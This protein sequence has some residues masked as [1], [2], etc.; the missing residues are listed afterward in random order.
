MPPAS[1][2]SSLPADGMTSSPA[3]PANGALLPGAV[4]RHATTDVPIC[5]PEATAAEVR[6]LLVSR[7]YACAADIAVCTERDGRTLLVGMLTIEEA[8]SAPDDAR[9][10]DLMDSDPPAVV[11]SLDEERAAWK[12]VQHGE[13]GL[14]V[15]GTD[16]SFRGIVPRGRLLSVLLRAHDEDMARLGGYLASTSSARHASEEP[17]RERLWHRLPWL[18]VGLLG[19][20]VAAFIVRGFEA[21]LAAD[22]RLAFFLPGIVYMADAVGTQT[23]AL[24]IRGMSVGVSLRRVVGSEVL[25]GVLVGLLLGVIA[26]GGI[27]VATG[28]A[29]L[30]ATVA[31]SLLLACTVATAVAM[32]LP[33]AL[34]RFNKDPAFGS[35]PLATVIQDLLSLVLYFAVA[36]VLLT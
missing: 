19:A 5:R 25:T 20:A 28:Q 9:A 14:A 10:E 7:R 26:F 3:A 27:L 21:E 17:V 6:R 13:S 12:A 31:I 16:G 4:D 36:S 30:A 15:V 23:E 29:D 35:G 34:R 2:R 33:A 32:A 11:R 1:S 24:V 22:V 18:L 8:L